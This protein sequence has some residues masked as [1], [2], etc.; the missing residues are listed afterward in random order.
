MLQK[1]TYKK[2]NFS[3]PSGPSERQR[4]LVQT[5]ELVARNVDEENIVNT[6]DTGDLTTFENCSTYCNE[7]IGDNRG[8]QLPLEELGKSDADHLTISK[9]SRVSGPEKKCSTP[10]PSMNMQV[11]KKPLVPPTT[12]KLSEPITQPSIQM[13]KLHTVTASS[14]ITISTPSTSAATPVT[15][16][17]IAPSKIT[18][19]KA[20]ESS[21]IKQ[22]IQKKSDRSIKNI[23]KGQN[24]VN[25]QHNESTNEPKTLNA[26]MI[27]AYGDENTEYNCS[28][29][30]PL[31][32][33]HFFNDEPVSEIPKLTVLKISNPKVSG[34]ISSAT[35]R[36][37]LNKIE[38]K[39]QL[40]PPTAGELTRTCPSILKPKLP[41]FT[42]TSTP[43]T[44][45]TALSTITTSKPSNAARSSRRKQKILEK[46]DWS[47]ENIDRSQNIV[48]ERQIESTNEPETL[49]A[50][51]I[52][53][54]GNENTKYN[55]SSHLPLEKIVKSHFFN[56]E[57]VSKIPKL[58]GLKKSNPKLSGTIS[59]ATSTPRTKTAVISPFPNPLQ[60]SF[61]TNFFPIDIENMK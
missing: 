49:G 11:T 52:E 14:T 44:S 28:S 39:K 58:I 2:S 60:S 41:S 56:D 38:E 33:S 7:N 1:K 17:I 32:K 30:L 54:H 26:D 25:K 5:I 59:S 46:T 48:N 34:T 27:E 21:K 55:C 23:D 57:P 24:G 3:G 36:L 51:M 12:K 20:R 10:S 43:S 31:G 45:V 29:Q 22:K 6:E 53:A 18:T 19:S 47:M 61:V 42:M 40:L 50:G 15:A 13:Q 37:P 35:I 8:S 9:T 4:K 16:T